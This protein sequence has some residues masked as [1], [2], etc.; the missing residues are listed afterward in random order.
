MS[1]RSSFV[2]SA[3][4]LAILGLSA[5]KTV[6]SDTFSY[7][8]NSFQP[9]AKKQ[10]EIKPPVETRSPIEGMGPG[11]QPPGMLMP[12]GGIPGIPGIPG[13]PAP[14]LPGL[15]GTTPPAPGT[16]PIPGIPGL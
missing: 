16:P 2:A 4:A 3:V 13:G 5:C 15:P 10:I 8:K 12:D 14:G 1:S 6:Y 9:P 11:L 7:R